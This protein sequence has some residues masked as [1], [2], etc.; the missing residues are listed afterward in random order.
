LTDKKYKKQLARVDDFT[1]EIEDHGILTCMLY[2]NKEGGLH[3]GFGGYSLDGYNEKLKRRVGTAGGMDFILRLLQVFGVSNPDEFTGKM[4]YALYDE[5]S[6]YI[7]GIEALAIDGG[8]SFVIDDWQNQWFPK[9]KPQ[10][11][12]HT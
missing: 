6:N 12:R 11:K 1:L 4:C 7:K 10:V 9:I 5:D 3:Q 8:K 2:L